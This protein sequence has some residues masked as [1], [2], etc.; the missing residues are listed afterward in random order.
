MILSK[1]QTKNKMAGHRLRDNHYN[2]IVAKSTIHHMH[3][4]RTLDTNERTLDTNERT[5]DTNERTLDNNDNNMQT[6]TGKTQSSTN[7]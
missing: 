7:R 4:E 3:N 1:E 5:L 6:N 2:R